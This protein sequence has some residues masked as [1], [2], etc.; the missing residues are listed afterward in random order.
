MKLAGNT[1]FIT[2]GGFGIGRRLAEAF[3]KLGNK[4]IISGRRRANLDEVVAFNPGMA[5]IGVRQTSRRRTL[6]RW[7]RPGYRRHGQERGIDAVHW[8]RL[9]SR[10]GTE[11][12]DRAGLSPISLSRLRQTVQRA[13]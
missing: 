3:H 9:D 1:I 7:K 2:G 10:F 6:F 8:V 11:R 5:A 4:V 13:Q 12:A